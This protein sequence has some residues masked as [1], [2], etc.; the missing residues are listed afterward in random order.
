MKTLEIHNVTRRQWTILDADREAAEELV[1]ELK[2]HSITAHLLL[3]RGIASLREAEEFLHPSVD[4]LYDP[5]LLPDMEKA[6]KRLAEAI[7]R[8]Q[9]ILIYGDYDVDGITGTAL[10]LRFLR[11]TGAEVSY[12]IPSRLR[13]GY[14]LHHIPIRRAKEEGVGLILSVDNGTSS[15]EEVE[16]IRQL[17]MDIIITDHHQVVEPHR[18]PRAVAVV[19]PKLSSSVYPFRDLCGV[20]VAFKLA[21]ALA[22]YLSPSERLSLEFRELLRESMAFVALGTIADVMPLVGENRIFVKFGLLALESSKAPG[23]H[24]LLDVAGLRDR[25]LEVSDISFR[26]APLI[27]AAGRL[28]EVGICLDLFQTSSSTEAYRYSRM[29][30]R[31]NERRR[32]MCLEIYKDVMAKLERSSQKDAPL[33]FLDSPHWHPG[34]I[35][36]VC[37]QLVHQY[38]RPVIL[39][40]VGED[41]IGKGSARSLS[42]F[43]LPRVLEESSELLLKFGGHMLAAGFEIEEANIPRF[44]ERVLGYARDFFGASPPLRTYTADAEV[45]FSELTPSLLRELDLFAPFGQSNRRPIFC[46]HN[47][48]VVGRPKRVGGRCAHL[49]LYLRQKDTVF[50]G[51]ALEMPQLYQRIISSRCPKFSILYS[52]QFYPGHKVDPIELELEDMIET[53]C[54]QPVSSKR[55][56]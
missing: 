13:E 56:R 49:K 47:I 19:N 2:V 30:A 37:S 52:P 50:K 38:G 6:V 12:F 54:I 5:F 51:I 46:T 42:H 28:G 11:F 43:D 31:Q 4:N 1:R 15:Y 22:R 55:L 26:V 34:L 32:K 53:C 9:R 25:S 3:Q 36:V 39:V 27:N 8:R 10:L 14:G 24:A 18:L 21:L 23:F 17:G 44:R 35:G 33:L 7:K 29:L 40:A 20:A 45:D 41:G 16:L 48:R